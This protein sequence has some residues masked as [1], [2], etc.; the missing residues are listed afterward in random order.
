MRAL[1]QPLTCKM[2][3]CGSRDRWLEQRRSGIGAS[4]AAV[5]LG[6]SPYKQPLELWAEL[7]G[8]VE[9][10]D[11]SEGQE[12][13]RWGN[14]L[15]PVVA[16]AYEEE[17]PGVR[18]HDLGRFTIC[19]SPAW[20]FMLATLDRVIE[21]A[22]GELGLLEI[23]TTN[24]RNAHQWEDEPPTHYQVQVQHQ[25]AVTG[26]K[27]GVL[28]C[29]IGGQK[30]VTK[31]VA[32]ND[33]FINILHTDLAQFWRLVETK[34][35][36]APKGP[37]SRDFLARLFPREQP[38]KI[39]E[40]PSKFDLIDE[41]IAEQKATRKLAEARIEELENEL[42]EAIQ[43]GEQGVTPAGIVYS[44]RTVERASYT[45]RPS[46]S[47]QLKRTDPNARFR[48]KEAA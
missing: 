20:P 38:G 16:D 7:T 25:L 6:L 11:Q 23:K 39:V 15:E 18:L 21:R 42:R 5:A 36:P 48:K 46:T 40:L 3:E 26:L 14:R 28:A 24:E 45:V 4:T 22:D 41:A 29:L 27:W 13:V 17:N 34:Q 37:L 43:D 8:A 30:L 33:D 9:P 35:P 47:R 2:E 31:H 1:K 12:R 19:R 44:W 32:R 10:Q